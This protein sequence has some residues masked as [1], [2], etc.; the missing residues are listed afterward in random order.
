MSIRTNVLAS[1]SETRR[2]WKFGLTASASMSLAETSTYV[3][4]FGK[5]FE[6][7]Q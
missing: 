2:G 6:W 5:I 3:I 1:L 7:L 4:M